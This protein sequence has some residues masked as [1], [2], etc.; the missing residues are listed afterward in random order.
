MPKFATAVLLALS[1]MA[2][3]FYV[4]IGTPSA[5][6]D[7]KAKGAVVL[8][9]LVG[10]HHPELGTVAVTAERT[11]GGKLESIPV[12]ATPLDKPGLYAITRQWP[13]D[14]QWQLR[15]VGKHADIKVS[16]V[17]IV[18]VQGETFERAGMVMKMEPA[19]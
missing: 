17:T 14:G 10:C 9:Q 16:T 6:S 15:I 13:A 2:G 3:G 18:K 19:Q 1:L 12:K 11:V 8:A 4:E 5:S 7:P